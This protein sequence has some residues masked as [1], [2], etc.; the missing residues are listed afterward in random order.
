MDLEAL[1]KSI[2]PMSEK[3]FKI[4]G[5]VIQEPNGNVRLY[6]SDAARPI[7]LAV[8]VEPHSAPDTLFKSAYHRWALG[9]L[10][11]NYQ[12]LEFILRAFL[13]GLPGAKGIGLPY[14]T[15]IYSCPVGT[16]LVV[17]DMTDYSQLSK[18]INRFNAAAASLGLQEQ[19]PT[20][21]IDV[22]HALAHGKVSAPADSDEMRVI[23]FDEPANGKVKVV[24]NETMNE[25]WFKKHTRQVYDAIMT[26]KKAIDH[27]NQKIV[28]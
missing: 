21:I 28:S 10:I 13:H 7:H 14:G 22:R 11:V 17:N 8:D 20:D 19:V 18:L 24:Y 25:E 9:T 6:K 2:E 23:K 16:E 12:S 15:D 5:Y 27:R 4:V 1:R 26:V 3:P